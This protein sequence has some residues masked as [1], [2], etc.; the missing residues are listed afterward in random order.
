MPTSFSLGS[1]CYKRD[2]RECVT[3]G[4]VHICGME[5]LCTNGSTTLAALLFVISCHGSQEDDRFIEVSS[6]LGL[7][8]KTAKLRRE[9][10]CQTEAQPRPSTPR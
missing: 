4:P 5:I 7:P 1:D 8:C 9:G 10:R 3:T 2:S 6:E